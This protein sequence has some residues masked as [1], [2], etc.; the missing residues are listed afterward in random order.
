MYSEEDYLELHDNVSDYQEKN[1]DL[2]SHILNDNM[3]VQ[4]IDNDIKIK[5]L[6]ELEA[7]QHLMI[8]KYNE[9]IAYSTNG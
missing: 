6:L 5:L 1:N 8:R 3:I 4:E 7:Y 2:I 9:L